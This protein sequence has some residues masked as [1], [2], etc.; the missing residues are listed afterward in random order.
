NSCTTIDRNSPLPSAVKAAA[1]PGRTKSPE[2][3]FA[4]GRRQGALR[5]AGD[6]LLGL[7]TSTAMSPRVGGWP[8]FGDVEIATRGSLRFTL[9]L[10]GAAARSD[11]RKQ[12]FRLLTKRGRGAFRRVATVVQL[13]SAQTLY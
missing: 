13:G 3:V 7:V 8:A 6:G 4:V 10:I 9:D 5:E 1:M 2:V 11:F 12:P